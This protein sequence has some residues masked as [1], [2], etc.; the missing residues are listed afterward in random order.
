MA[1]VEENKEK[2][3]AVLSYDWLV[4]ENKV[5]CSKGV[6]SDM[7][8]F[9]DEKYKKIVQEEHEWIKSISQKYSI[10][11]GQQIDSSAKY[12]R[13]SCTRCRNYLYLSSLRCADCH[14]NYCSRDFHN[15][16]LGNYELVYREPNADRK[17][18]TAFLAKGKKET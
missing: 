8:K 10:K 5:R 15:C 11:T 2:K 17:W 18:I 1:F 12:D 14:K 6:S 9:I 3:P 7:Q 16:C 13:N 4:Y